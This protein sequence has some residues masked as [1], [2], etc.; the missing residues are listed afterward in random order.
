MET[1]KI[2][3]V[4]VITVSKNSAATL[5]RALQSVAEQ[6][7][8][9]VEHIVIDGASTDLSMEIVERYRSHLAHVVSEPDKGIYDAMNKGLCLASGDI[10]CFL[11]ADDFYAHKGVLSQ[12]AMQMRE[13]RLDALMGDVAFFHKKNPN[14]TIRRYRS[15]RFKPG[16]LAWGWMPAHPA[17]FVRRIGHFKIDYRVAGDFEYIV[18]IFHKQTL[19]YDYMDQVLVYMQTGGASNN[20]WRSK[21]LLNQEVLR[22]CKENGLET[23]M[24]KIVSKYPFKLLEYFLK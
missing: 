21:I 8:P 20:S 15:A 10:V 6:N 19:S 22:A 13:L 7:W 12:V 2:L 3:Q 1:S 16:R 9:A 23:N 11:N 18:R 17:L 14:L 4:S 5:E 24:L